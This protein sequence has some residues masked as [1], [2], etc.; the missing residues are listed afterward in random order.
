MGSVSI[1]Y[2]LQQGMGTALTDKYSLLHFAVG[3]VAYYWGISFLNIMI[4]HTLF[5]WLE[6]TPTGMWLINTY[7][8]FWPGGKPAPD[9][10]VNRVGDTLWTAV[11]WGLSHW[12][13]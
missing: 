2:T 6:N 4:L 12:I 9:T 13:A 3:I 1:F 7:I 5:E 11:G 10:M 8:K